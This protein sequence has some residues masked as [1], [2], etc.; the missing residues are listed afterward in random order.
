[1]RTSGKLKHEHPRAWYNSTEFVPS[2]WVFVFDFALGSGRCFRANKHYTAKSIDTSAS[3]PY[4]IAYGAMKWFAQRGTPRNQKQ[5]TAFSVQFVPAMR[6]ICTK[7]AVSCISFRSVLTYLAAA[8]TAFQVERMRG[9]KRGR[10]REGGREKER[11]RKRE[12]E[13]RLVFKAVPLLPRYRHVIAT[14]SPRDCT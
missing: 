4:S 6:T 2:R 9:R 7:S 12:R 1:M 3:R 10:G 5:E 13:S 14:L 11:E 8:E